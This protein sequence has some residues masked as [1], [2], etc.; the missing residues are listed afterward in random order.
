MSRIVKSKRKS[1]YSKPSN[2]S[3]SKSSKSSRSK[4][5]KLSKTPRSRSPKSP[6][7]PK[8][9]PKTSP[10]TPKIHCQSLVKNG[11]R[12]SRTARISFDLTKGVKIW[13]IDVI[14]KFN[15]CFFCTQHAA[16]YTGYGMVE[17]GMFLASMDLDWDEYIALNPQYLDKK[18]KEMGFSR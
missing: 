12:C 16:V 11:K 15:C 2:P 3:K 1:H 14:P 6:K 10:G 9:P 8:S 13:G 17:I 5:R 4:S 18:M 7:S